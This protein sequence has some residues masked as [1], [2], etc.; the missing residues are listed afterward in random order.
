MDRVV[1]KAAIIISLILTVTASTCLAQEPRLVKGLEFLT[2]FSKAKLHGQGNYLLYPLIFDVNFDLKQPLEKVGVRPP[3][4]F[5]FGIEPFVSYVSEPRSDVETGAGF[6][7]KFGIL[8][9]TS[10]FQPFGRIGLG[11]LYMS[12]DTREQSTKFNFYEQGG[13]GA[14]YFLN[15]NFGLTMECRIRH[16]SNAG[17]RQPNHGINNLSY[18]L[19]VI[20]QY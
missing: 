16:L 1:R 9:E 12:L 5:Q 13:V 20:Y 10:R 4:L 14:H 3:G 17:I 11:V 19:G 6:M 8:P 7:L 2:G 18:L 15:N